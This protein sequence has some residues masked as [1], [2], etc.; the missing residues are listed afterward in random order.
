MSGAATAA[1]ASGEVPP[2]PDTLPPLRDSVLAG[3][4]FGGANAMV[5][6]ALAC[7]VSVD[8][9]ATAEA[10]FGP[11]LLRRLGADAAGLRAA[12]D[13]DIAAIDALIGAQLDAILHHT[14]LRRLEG[15]WRGVAWLVDGVESGARVKVKLLSA[16][17]A[18]VCRD[19]ERAAEFDQSQLFRKIYEDEFGSPGGEPYG[20]L[21]MD[22]EIRHRAGPH[23][24]G[25]G[26]PTDDVG[27][28]T[29]LA[30]VAAAAF[31]PTVVAASPAL[32]GVDGFAEL[33]N[34][35]D[36]AAPLRTAEAQRWRTLSG[37]DDI[38]FIAVTLPRVLAR[39]PW[40]DDPARHDGFRYSEYAPDSECR[41]WT[42]SG[43]AFA[44]AAV[45]AFAGFGWPADVRGVETDRRGGGLVDRLALEPFATDRDEVWVRPSLE[46]VLTDRQERALIDI[47]LMPITAI[48]YSNDAVFPAV[49]SLQAPTP[50]TST[51]ATANARLSSQFNSMLCVSRFAH[52]LKLLGRGMVGAFRTAD[53]IERQLKKWLDGYVN[54][55]IG[56]T[57][58]ARARFPLVN[59]RVTVQ[60]RPG[61]PGVFGC[62]IML[63]PHFQ[64]DDVA[65]QFRL[66]TEIAAP[67][68]SRA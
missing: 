54:G 43:Y 56:A 6:E 40:R 13:R 20:L 41:V 29:L 30:G 1:R 34:A 14:R 22:H 44:A 11:A 16:G 2:A 3:R 37:L 12:I 62:V 38:R 18:E 50:Y 42:T 15:T 32:L 28:L 58:D 66:V 49:P 33:A 61:R 63:Q 55:N 39:P 52:V 48:P 45:R 10:W 4:H 27:A 35:A 31:V 17:W 64:L 60:E 36:P 47:G 26:A 53:E 9:A 21:V 68:A 5:A 7:F 19:L 24:S 59:A 65:A 51:A 57:G 46:I 23:L 67:G 8:G 25:S